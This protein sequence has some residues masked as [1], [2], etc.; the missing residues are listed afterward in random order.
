MKLQQHQIPYKISGGA[1]FF[2]KAAIKAVM[3]YLRLIVNPDDDNAFLRAINT[4]RRQIGTSPLEALGRYATE[5]VISLFAAVDEVGIESQLP[6]NSLERLRRFT[7]WL[8]QV[9]RRCDVAQAVSAIREMLEDMDYLGWLHQN[10]ST[11]KAAARRWE[12]VT[13]LVESLA[14]IMLRDDEGEPS[15]MQDSIVRLVV[16]DLLER[17]VEEAHMNRVQKV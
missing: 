6:K 12:N 1:S 5:R 7:H 9:T 10:S 14:K 15:T 2:A 17:L 13:Y 4:P 3:A 11:P 16:R 8:N